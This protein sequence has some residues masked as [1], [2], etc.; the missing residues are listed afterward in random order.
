ML[1][2]GTS[3]FWREVGKNNLPQPVKI[4]GLTRWRLADLV[5]CVEEMSPKKTDVPKLS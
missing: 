5:R 2:M 4:G 3:T 1:S